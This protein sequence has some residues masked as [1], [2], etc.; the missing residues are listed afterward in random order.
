MRLPRWLDIIIPRFLTEDVAVEL[1]ECAHCDEQH[2]LP[3]CAMYDV[4]LGETFDGVATMRSFNL[5][6]FGL[7]PRIIG[8]PRPWINPH[9]EAYS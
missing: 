7:F 1:L 3:V 8:E 5:F 6:G 4:A 9:D 2:V